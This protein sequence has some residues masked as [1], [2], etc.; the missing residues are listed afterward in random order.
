[1]NTKEKPITPLERVMGRDGDELKCTVFP[2]GNVSFHIW[3]IKA[4]KG[5]KCMCGKEV[6]Q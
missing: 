2:S 4:K 1:M 3:P 5:S 6:K